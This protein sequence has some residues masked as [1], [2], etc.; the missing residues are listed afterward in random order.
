MT[1]AGRCSCHPID[2][3]RGEARA[4]YMMG[5]ET[6][7]GRQ[8]RTT[9]ESIKIHI[10]NSFY[11]FK[12]FKSIAFVIFGILEKDCIGD[13]SIIDSKILEGQ[14]CPPLVPPLD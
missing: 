3:G 13:L 8:M 4:F 9:K 6:L 5:Q 2:E 7:E 10:N 12:S 11:V 1:L 14:I